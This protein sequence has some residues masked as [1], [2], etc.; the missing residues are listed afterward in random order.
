MT[1]TNLPFYIGP[2]AIARLLSHLADLNTSNLILVCDQNQYA[3]LGERVEGQLKSAGYGVITVVLEGE[4]IGANEESVVQVLQATNDT[5]QL[6]LAVGSGTV[7]DITR[8]V[9]FHSKSYFISLPTA[10][11][12][13]GFASHGSAMTIKNLKQSRY[14]RPPL[15]IYADI[16]TLVNAPDD[17]IAAGFGD[18]FGKFTAVAD[19]KIANLVNG[20][21]YDQEIAD[22][23]RKA[24]DLV[25][26]QSFLI[27]EARLTSIQTVMEALIEEGLC[28]LDFGASRPA[29]G[30]EHSFA[31]YWETMLH[32]EGRPAV[33]HGA[34]VGLATILIAKYFEIIRQLTQK[35]VKAQLDNHPKFDPEEE[36][37]KILTGYGDYIGQFII[38]IQSDHL[39]L[40]QDRYNQLQRNLHNNWQQIQEIAAEVPE[41]N[42][43]T[44][45]IKNV[46]G[47]TLPSDLGLTPKD[48][49]GAVD[50]AQYMRQ[51][52]T[53]LNI[54]QMLGIR[55]EF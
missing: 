27:K 13:D 55:P 24:R 28:M 17:L 44:S 53:I 33:L 15:G 34:K 8:F 43:I 12:V 49:Q 16:D 30:A 7:T 54:F 37:Q 23:S 47:P 2:E 31:H 9:S 29:S 46:N 3:A 10:P 32:W 51:S 48:L 5:E 25:A 6:F 26:E 19:W 45:L 20:D 50:Y 36:R 35:Q 40:T 4:E 21:A 42:E 41:P 22:R 38:G 14:T 52:F 11:S 1:N 39:G 18:M